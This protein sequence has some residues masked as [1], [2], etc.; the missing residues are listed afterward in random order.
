MFTFQEMDTMLTKES[1]NSA[2]FKV[3]R[4][5]VGS[6][7]GGLSN[8]LISAASMAKVENAD[9]TDNITGFTGNS[10]TGGKVSVKERVNNKIIL[11]FVS[12]L[13][14]WDYQLNDKIQVDWL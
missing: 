14:Y 3:V 5:T 9:S 12:F 8:V 7:L 11:K 6:F 4:D 10:S 1:Q 2:G 13:S